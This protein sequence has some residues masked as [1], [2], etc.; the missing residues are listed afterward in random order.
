[1]SVRRTLQAIVCAPVAEKNTSSFGTV[2]ASFVSRQRSLWTHER[3]SNSYVFSRVTVE[4][5]LQ[6]DG[7]ELSID[8]LCT[9]LHSY[10]GIFSQETHACTV[11]ARNC[12]ICTHVRTPTNPSLN[13]YSTYSIDHI[14]QVN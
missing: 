5:D 14:F 3:Y 4:M 9:L 8:V 7:L 10:L 6:G 12:P 1:M 2:V 11:V 13:K